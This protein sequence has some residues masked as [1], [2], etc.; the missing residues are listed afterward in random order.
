MIL[1]L[2]WAPVTSHCLLERLP[3]FEF[4]SCCQHDESDRTAG[5]EQEDCSGDSCAVVEDGFYKIQDN[6]DAVP[7]PTLTIAFLLEVL[8][9]QRL[10][11]NDSSGDV[12]RAALPPPTLQACWRFSYR[13]A[14]PVRAPSFLA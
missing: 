12:L 14:V 10:A 7:A 5:H 4:L 13:A 11:A 9:E 3:G 2:L 8:S 1:A 6:G